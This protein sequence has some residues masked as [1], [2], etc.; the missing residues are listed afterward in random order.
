MAKATETPE[1]VQKE[2]ALP[3]TIE[4]TVKIPGT[5]DIKFD[6]KLNINGKETDYAENIQGRIE[7]S[8]LYMTR[9]WYKNVPQQKKSE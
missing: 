4:I 3:A 8:F 5:K 7:E 2:L 9:M 1:T 6:Y